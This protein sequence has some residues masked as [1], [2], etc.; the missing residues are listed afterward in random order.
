MLGTGNTLESRE[1]RPE[2]SKDGNRD[3]DS[4]IEKVQE[5]FHDEESENMM[6]NNGQ[7][8]AVTSLEVS[9]KESKKVNISGSQEDAEDNSKEANDAIAEKEVESQSKEVND[10]GSKKEDDN[11]NKEANADGENKEV[12]GSGSHEVIGD[13]S[14]EANDGSLVDDT[15]STTRRIDVPSSKVT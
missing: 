10:G 5:P 8:E 12:N 13:E 7:P 9:V 15:Q 2:E 14:K 6:D 4:V 3:G 11:E 1:E